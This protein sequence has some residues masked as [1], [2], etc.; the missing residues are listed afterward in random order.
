MSVISY[1]QN[2]EDIMLWRALKHIDKGFYIDIGAWSPDLDSVTRIF[3]EHG[4]S[5][6]NVE[7]NPIFNDQLQEKRPR[8]RNLCLAV[9][10][11]EG[12]SVIN[13]M[14]NPGLSTLDDSIAEKHQNTGLKIERQ[15]VQIITLST[16]W[17]QF[18]IDDQAVHFLK[19]D[20]EGFEKKVLLGNDW[21]KYRPWVVLIEATQPMSQVDSYQD[22]ESILLAANY[23]FV[24]ADG[25][26]RFYV[27]GE[28]KELIP[29][30]QYPP[31]VFDN[32]VL[33]SQHLAQDKQLKAEV[34]AQQ[35]EAKAR[36]TEVKAQ[37]AEAKAKEAEAKAK[38]AEVK[39]QQAEAKTLKVE[40]KIRLIEA[41][42]QSVKT[43]LTTVYV[44]RSWRITKPLREF[45][46]LIQRIKYKLVIFRQKIIQK[47][48]LKS[49]IKR[50]AQKTIAFLLDCRWLRTKAVQIIQ[51]V[52]WL[53]Q[54]LRGVLLR[55]HNLP[56]QNANELTSPIN[57]RNVQ[58]TPHAQDVYIKLK[59]AIDE[60]R[61]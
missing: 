5:G 50:G 19:I 61:N 12:N 52:P 32:F 21:A 31:N 51:Q 41:K 30:F 56:G 11:K 24:Y 3:Y 43:E 54:W 23:F 37:Q 26:N 39:M 25:L 45:S 18:I 38:E 55:L 40:E 29:S 34:K 27:S 49:F 44:S 28:H 8:D 2:F 15:Q 60:N 33:H 1:A 57:R 16:I 13:M 9:G 59:N 4:W 17:Q 7:P 20:V 42:A 58:L 14:T 35:A 6:I 46:Y 10:E 48:S 53:E 36:K 22:W 47:Q